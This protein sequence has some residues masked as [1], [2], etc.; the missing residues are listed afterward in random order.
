VTPT[1]LRLDRPALI[2]RALVELVAEN[3][4]RGTSMAAVAER[5][6]VAAGTAY[7]HYKSKDELVVAAFREVKTDLGIAGAAGIDASAEPADR[8]RQLWDNVYSHLGAD[9]ARARFLMQFEASP[10]AA[11]AHAD[12]IAEEDDQLMEAAM[13][14][15]MARLLIDAP[16][17]I[18]FDLGLGPAVRMAASG[19]AVDGVVLECVA[20]ACW[21]AI[22][23]A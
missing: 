21:R 7:V 2:R 10:Y 22:T 15:D 19:A 23:R 16:V 20:Q 11:R 5:A 6:G 4:F 14:T 17:E 3:G 1:T 13:A 18:L 8:F 9:P 12:Y